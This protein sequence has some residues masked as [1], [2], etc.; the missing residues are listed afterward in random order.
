MVEGAPYGIF[1][2]G[3]DGRFWE[4]NSALQEMLGY[5]SPADLLNANLGDHVFRNPS[6]FHRLIELLGSEA[7]FKNVEMEWKRRDDFPITVLCSGRRVEGG[8]ENSTYNEV[9]V[10]DI[11]ERRVLES[12]NC[13]RQQ[14]WRL[15]GSSRVGL[16]TILIICS[17]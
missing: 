6:D 4:V 8:D 1:R 13:G 14:R 2:A 7:E 15:W 17:A 10:E 11:T 5:R 12:V 3:V 9:F 16:P